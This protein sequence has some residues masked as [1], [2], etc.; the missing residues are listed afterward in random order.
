[1]VVSSERD[2]P[3]YLVSGCLISSHEAVKI[4][5]SSLLKILNENTGK[6]DILYQKTLEIDKN[7]G[8][9]KFSKQSINEITILTDR[10]DDLVTTMLGV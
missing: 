3:C 9:D 2:T 5:I 1:M 4:P 10:Y 6:Y 7:I 8:V